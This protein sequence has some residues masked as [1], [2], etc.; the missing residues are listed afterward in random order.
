MTRLGSIFKVYY[1]FCGLGFYRFL[2]LGFEN[3]A[4]LVFILFSSSAIMEIEWMDFMQKL[5]VKE[6]FKCVGC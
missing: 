3:Y 1:V 5:E 4:C 2:L 6:V